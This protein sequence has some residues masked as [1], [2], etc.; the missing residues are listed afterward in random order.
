MTKKKPKEK[1]EEILSG[2]TIELM[3][4]GLT[5]YIGHCIQLAPDVKSINRLIIAILMEEVLK[6]SQIKI[7][8]PCDLRL[9]KPM[10]ESV[11]VAL[12]Q[13]IQELGR[14]SNTTEEEIKT[15]KEKII[16]YMSIIQ[17][18]QEDILQEK[19]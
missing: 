14:Q 10:F 15:N 11:I 19:S 2:N 6:A 17:S 13:N 8:T 12:K 16:S 1:E 9:L 18:I 3:R 7:D 4:A 5:N